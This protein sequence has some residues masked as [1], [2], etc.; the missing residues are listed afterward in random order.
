MSA[1]SHPA[2]APVTRAA[3]REN[4]RR[5]SHNTRQTRASNRQPRETRAGG[6]PSTSA[7]I[8]PTRTW[9]VVPSR[10][11]ASPSGRA[12]VVPVY[13]G[14]FERQDGLASTWPDTSRRY[15]EYLANWVQDVE[16]TIEYLETRRDLDMNRLSYYGAS[17]GGRLG[18]IIPAVEPRFKAV[19]LTSAGLASGTAQPEVDQINFVTR[20]RQPVLMLNGRFDAIEPVETAQRPLF[21]LLGTPKDQKKWVVFEDDHAMPAHI[22]ELSREAMAWLDLYVGSVK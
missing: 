6:N 12:L 3:H 17:W 14:T 16:R 7:I 19:I 10:I 13:R 9:K 4:D 20:V 5:E 1:N 18:A 15:S 2:L 11:S 21:E 22:N 8:R